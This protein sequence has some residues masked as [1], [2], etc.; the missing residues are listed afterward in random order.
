MQL[1]P[2]PSEIPDDASFRLARCYRLI[3]LIARRARKQAAKE[4]ESLSSVELDSENA[5]QASIPL[6]GD[7][8][9]ESAS[10]VKRVLRKAKSND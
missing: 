1:D 6:P 3:E 7:I 5:A 10:P 4:K 8:I 2:M 9:S